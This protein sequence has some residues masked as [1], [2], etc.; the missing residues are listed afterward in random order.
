MEPVM[1]ATILPSVKSKTNFPAAAVEARLQ[2]ELIR[3]VKMQADLEGRT[4]PSSSA[5]LV[6]APSTLDFG[7]GRSAVRS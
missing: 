6:T 5:A 2:E 1:P 3:V 7:G 4:L